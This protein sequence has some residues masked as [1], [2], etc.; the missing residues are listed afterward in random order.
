MVSC[1]VTP[2]AQLMAT[3]YEKLARIFW[4]SE[5]YLFHA[6][7]YYKFFALS[8]SQNKALSDEDRRNMASAVVLAALAIPIY[9]GSGPGASSS[10]S[11]LGGSGLDVDNERDKKSKLAAALL[12]HSSLPSREALLGELV[13]K[14]ALKLVRP[15][16][17]AL[18]RT[19]QVDFFP[20]TL[21][22]RSLPVL[23]KLRKEAGP[24]VAS[25][26]TVGGSG[27]VA[28]NSLSQYVP[29]LERLLVFRTLQQL[30]SVYSTLSLEVFDGLCGGLGS[31]TRLDVQKLIARAVKGGQLSVRM[32]HRAGVLRFGGDAG[33]AANMRKQLTQLAARLHAV[34]ESIAPGAAA[35]TAASD[36]K[37]SH[38]RSAVFDAAV[39]DMSESPAKALARREEIELRKE[40]AER[41]RQIMERRVSSARRGTY[42][43]VRER[44]SPVQEAA[45]V[46]MIPRNTRLQ[47]STSCDNQRL[48]V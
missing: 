20:L 35:A 45:A 31:M 41:R 36:S 44:A 14:G 8:V 16:V 30:S 27:G 42:R 43:R 1:D 4:V 33:E 46:C 17:A 32:D 11:A 12:K 22:A 9:A 34:V 40:S 10:T 39:R 24:T 7:A 28:A 23:E 15:E 19:L 29:N 37:A 3:Y 48:C 47:F 2:K 25:S 26:G 21:V 18:F 5:N 6:Y 38:R 13:A